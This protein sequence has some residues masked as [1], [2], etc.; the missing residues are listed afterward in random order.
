MTAEGAE[1]QMN[2]IEARADVETAS[3][4]SS[5]LWLFILSYLME[6]TTATPK[7]SM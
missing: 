7:F 2:T 3:M 5:I 6:I 4:I 1:I